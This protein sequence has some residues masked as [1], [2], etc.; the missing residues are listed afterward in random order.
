MILAF[1]AV[2]ANRKLYENKD[3]LNLSTM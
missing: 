3:A 1:E 2:C